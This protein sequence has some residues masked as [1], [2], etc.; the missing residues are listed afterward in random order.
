MGRKRSKPRTLDPKLDVLQA[1][2]VRHIVNEDRGL[3]ASVVQRHERAKA[4]LPG[5]IPQLEVHTC[6]VD[7]ELLGEKACTDGGGPAMTEVARCR[8]VDERSL[9]DALTA[10]CAVQ[11]CQSR[12]AVAKYTLTRTDYDLGLEVLRCRIGRPPCSPSRSGHSQRV[13]PSC[14]DHRFDRSRSSHRWCCARRRASRR[15]AIQFDG[16][17]D[18]ALFEARK[19][20]DAARAL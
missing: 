18:L 3:R 7:G 1:R 10:D 5:G 2:F 15:G 13:R 8:A 20:E 4:L 14:R 17:R 6:V 11:G 9:A 19:R 16:G 12:K